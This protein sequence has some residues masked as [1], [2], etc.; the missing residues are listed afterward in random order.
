[1]E[2]KQNA[3]KDEGIRYVIVN[4]KVQK[5]YLSYERG[6]I[7]YL[8]KKK[9]IDVKDTPQPFFMSAVFTEKEKAEERII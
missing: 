2:Y 9:I 3:I 8:R 7:A 6:N 1:M 4:N 5:R